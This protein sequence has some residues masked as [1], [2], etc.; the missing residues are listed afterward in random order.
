MITPSFALTATERVLP[1]LALDFT[2]ASLDARISV[3][4]AANTATAI[5]SSGVIA[6]VNANLPRFDYN[7]TTLACRGLLIEESRKNILLNSLI[8]GTSLSTQSV[9]TTATAYTLSFYGTGSIVLSGTASATVSGTGAYPTRTTST[10]TPTAGTLTLTVSGTVQYAQL[11]AGGFVTS[12]IPT[13]STAGGITRNADVVTMTGTNFSSWFNN[14]EGAFSFVGDC[15]ASGVSARLLNCSDGTAG[16]KIENV[17]SSGGAIQTLVFS[18]GAA[19][20]SNT[21]ALNTQFKTTFAYKA[22]SLA[23]SLNA[24]NVAGDSSVTIPTVNRL[25]FGATGTNIAY[26]NG[27]IAKVSYWPQRLINAEVQ[28]FSK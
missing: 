18:D 27:H 17:R 20:T 11:E 25:T 5:N 3:T 4:R 8:D 19:T 28:A 12:F 26:I 24:G 1:R 23:T 10:F 15:G 22:N 16:N 2:T 6:V 21:V 13:D 7:P 14:T 9:T